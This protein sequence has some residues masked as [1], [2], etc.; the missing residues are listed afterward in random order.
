MNS[1]ATLP[2][3]ACGP[4]LTAEWQV[5][6][7]SGDFNPTLAPAWFSVIVAA[8]CPDG[9]RVELLTRREPDGRLSAVL[10]YFRARRK[11][12]GIAVSVLQSGSNLMSYHAG[13]VATKGIEEVLEILLRRV[14]SWDVAHFANVPLESATAAALNSL[15]ARLGSHLQVVQGDESPFLS[16]VGTWDGYLA[17]RS[18]KFRYKYR[19]R[20][21]QFADASVFSLRWLTAPTDVEQLLA[22]MLAVERQ[23][24]KS[25][26]GLS[27]VA[28]EMELN[29]HRRLLPVLAREGALLANVLH[30]AARP[31]AYSLCCHYGGW[32]GH[33]K[34]SFDQEFAA[35]SPGGYV[36]DVSVERA[37][38]LKAREF[39]FLGDA[40]PHKLA[41][42]STTRRHVDFFIFGRTWK[43]RMMG[44]AKRWRRGGWSAKPAVAA[45][46]SPASTVLNGRCGDA[47]AC[48]YWSD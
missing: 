18:K 38:D 31:I 33:L 28:R 32:V 5:L 27:I 47:V 42:T 48:Q 40:V 10:P 12:H 20:R 4:E 7:R 24:W 14:A 23:S 11:M 13:V 19:Q 8:L 41:W 21:E 36:I 16:I 22:A 9:C 34:T 29:Y 45:I 25:G 2:F 6:A 39:D 17:T 15:A 46:D 44:L 26:A 35:L 30:R 1:F 37:F 3:P 43:G